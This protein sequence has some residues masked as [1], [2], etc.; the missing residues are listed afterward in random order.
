MEHS[1]IGIDIGGT[2]TVFGIIDKKGNC[3]KI[4]SIKTK[5]YEDVN[6]YIC[7]L[8]GK[9]S[10]IAEIYLSEGYLI[11]GIGIGAPNGNYFKGTIEFAP[12]LNWKGV[13]NFTELFRKYFDYPV[14]LDNDAN[15]A[16]IGEMMF[17]SARGMKNFVV[18]TLGTGLGSGFVVNGELLYG[19]DGFAGELG[20]TIIFINGRQCGCG[21]KGCLEQYA[22]ATGIV[23]NYF[24]MLSHDSENSLIAEKLN[25]KFTSEAEHPKFKITSEMIHKFALAGNNAALAA[26]EFTGKLLGLALSNVVTITSPEAIFLTGGLSEAGD[27]ILEPTKRYM[28]EIML[29]IFRNKVKLLKSGLKGKNAAILG[30]GALVWR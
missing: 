14:Y 9:I 27:F 3:L 5:E 10:E 12:N 2:N 4:N 6:S 7:A 26:F 17:G 29:P 20:H 8:S 24:E 21:R 15:T 16:A 11:D 23:K 30:A 28:E 19:S 22:S 18:I 25:I 13:V 1:A